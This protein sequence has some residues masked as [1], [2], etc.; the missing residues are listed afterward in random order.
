[1]PLW[2]WFFLLL[3]LWLLLLWF[4]LLLLWSSLWWWWLEELVDW[5]LWS[6]V[7]LLAQRLALVKFY[8][9]S[10]RYLISRSLH[11]VGTL[12]ELYLVGMIITTF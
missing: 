4:S 3:L 10:V 1:M 7:V 12:N 2:W 6:L 11:I 8:Q 5:L 9:L